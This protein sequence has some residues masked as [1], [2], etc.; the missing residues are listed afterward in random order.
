MF[1]FLRFSFSV[2]PFWNHCIVETVNLTGSRTLRRALT[3]TAHLSRNRRLS[4]TVS[5]VPSGLPFFQ[6][7][8]Q[9]FRGS[10]EASPDRL[11][12]FRRD[13]PEDNSSRKEPGYAAGNGTFSGNQYK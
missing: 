6:D 3:D 7:L 1:H 11:L 9:V 8:S 4:A 13:L 2:F 5:T 12:S 10:P